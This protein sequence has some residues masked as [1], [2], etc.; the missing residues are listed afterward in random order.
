MTLIPRLPAT[1][2]N[3]AFA[4]TLADDE[5]TIQTKVLVARKM[6]DGEQ[7]AKLPER[8]KQ[9]VTGEFSLNVAR[10]TITA[11]TDGLNVIDWQAIPQHDLLSVAEVNVEAAQAQEEKIKGSGLGDWAKHMWE[12][13]GLDVAQQTAYVT[14]KR[15]GEAFVLIAP[16]PKNEGKIVASVFQRWTDSEVKGDDFGMKMFYENDDPQQAA[17]Y[18]SKWWTEIDPDTLKATKRRNLYFPD[19]VEKYKIGG[20]LGWEEHRDEGDT[21]WPLPWVDSAG[22]PLGIPVAHFRNEDDEPGAEQVWPLQGA[23]NKSL[24]D[25]LAASDATAFR[26]FVAT[27]GWVPTADGLPMAADKANALK[28][29]PGMTIVTRLPADQAGLDVIEGANVAPMLEFVDKLIA[30]V[31]VVS[32]IPI[33]AFQLTRQLAGADTLKE[34]KEPMT[35]MIERDQLRFGRGWQL[36]LE[37]ARK[38]TNTFLGGSIPTEYSFQPTWAPAR[39]VDPMAK[40]QEANSLKAL[41]VPS[42]MVWAKAGLTQEEIDQAK[43]SPEYQAT[44]AAQQNALRGGP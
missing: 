44:L 1:L 32:R 37:M 2:T 25:G 12:A 43:S 41:G 40:Y 34:Q 15:D 18:A 23:V 24:I 20:K 6:H 33:S 13:L 17:L 9:Y 38:I 4:K 35:R 31:S 19:R 10:P 29:Q 7:G 21:A 26:T 27:G 5:K 14:A 28:I 8:L 3:L 22:E 39:V 30:Y 42:E 36:V 16:D 11:V